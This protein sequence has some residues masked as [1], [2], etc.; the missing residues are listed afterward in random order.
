MSGFLSASTLCMVKQ[1]SDPQEI[2]CS[3]RVDKVSALVV[4]LLGSVLIAA[5]FYLLFGSVG[6]IPALTS[7]AFFLLSGA[8]VLILSLFNFSKLS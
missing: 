2:L 7:G 8:A 5:G 1:H 6:T 4:A 3:A